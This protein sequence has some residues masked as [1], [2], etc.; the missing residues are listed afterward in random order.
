VTARNDV[1]DDLE[2]VVLPVTGAR[3]IVATEVVQ[4]LWSGYGQIVRCHLDPGPSVIV[5]WVRWP[6]EQRHPRGWS[7]DRSHERK[8]HSYR[9]ESAWYERYANR[10]GDRCRVPE[11]LA[12]DTRTDGVMMV[13]EDLDA[14]GFPGRRDAVGP[15]ELDA[16]LAWLANFHATFMGQ[17]PDGLWEA[18]PFQTLVHGDAKLANFCFDLEGEAVA[19]VD[20]Q[21]VGGGCGMKDV[22]YFIGSC[23][24][25]DETEE[26]ATELLDRYFELLREALDHTGTTLDLSALEA[27][28]RSLYPLAWT[29]FT[30]FLRGW[31]PGPEE[32]DDD[33]GRLTADHFWCIDPLDGTL[34]FVEGTP[35][36]SVSIALVRRDGTPLIGVVYDPV[37]ATLLQAVRGGG[38]RR[39]GQPW[40]PTAAD[41]A[42]ELALFADRSSLQRADHPET[43]TA[44]DE[45]AHDRG[46]SGVRVEAT[47]GGVLNACA[48]LA[49][50]P[51]C[52]FK[53]PAPTGGGSL[54]D[55]AAT[56]C[57]FAEAGAVATDIHGDPLDLNRDDSTAMNHRGVLYATDAALAGRLRAM[58]GGA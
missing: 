32:R 40:E 49:H 23:L 38:V 5:K 12:L 25:E 44:L 18:S 14:A 34:P 11:L 53:R 21:Y 45:I 42:P 58:I 56:A 16:C 48:V 57:I 31:S 1:T 2:A 27:D 43:V 6:D 26:K 52:Y 50:P 15:K 24:D 19:A 28:W 47:R 4:S 29:D 36:Y 22:A 51:A 39:N 30:R 33:G 17:A 20:F 46:L 13:V 3:S 37:T 10:C 7:T 35:G 9:V 55:F 54:W 41:A 8:L